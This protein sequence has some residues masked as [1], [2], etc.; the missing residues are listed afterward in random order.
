[1]KRLIHAALGAIGLQII[2]KRD[3][4]GLLE[5]FFITVK[6]L[7]F[8]PTY[9]IDVGANRGEWT[10]KSLLYY[11]DAAVTMIEPQEHLKAHV[12]DLLTRPNIK[13]I[14]AGVGAENKV[15]KFTI[16]EHDHSS[17]FVISEQAAAEHKMKQIDMQL[18]T[19]N[20]VVAD[21]EGKIPDLVKVDAEGL[22]LEVIKGASD[23]LGKTEIILLEAAICANG[24]ENKISLTINKMNELGYEPF[25]ITDLNYSPR[26]GILWLAE[27]VFVRKGG[28]VMSKISSQY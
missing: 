26:Q 23:L 20:K 12:K 8:E 10:R 9:I 13:W 18:V 28:F 21:N 2:K 24:I 14:T 16:A 19:L 6:N 25:D 1:M 5:H 7:G 17:T 4:F 22:D 3:R 27:I 11:P 15:A